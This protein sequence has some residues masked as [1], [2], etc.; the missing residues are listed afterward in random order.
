M[1]ISIFLAQWWGVLLLVMGSS[2]LVRREGV[3]KL[4]KEFASSNPSPGYFVGLIEFALGLT[5]AL[6]YSNLNAGWQGVV[7]ILNWLVL[8]EG[9]TYL[10]APSSFFTGMMKRFNTP[11]N[12]YVGGAISL[13]LGAW[14][15]GVGFGII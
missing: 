7:T 11:M 8:I 13:V 6:L 10:F 15:A 3:M 5:L 1:E 9:T 4:M 2:I 12:Y 14:L